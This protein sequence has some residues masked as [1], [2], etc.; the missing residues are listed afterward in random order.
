MADTTNNAT[1]P[2]VSTAI[3][4]CKKY[5]KELHAVIYFLLQNYSEFIIKSKQII[6]WQ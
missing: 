5:C 6:K 2:T 4:Y 1:V 3:L